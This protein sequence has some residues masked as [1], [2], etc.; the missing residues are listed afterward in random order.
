MDHDEW[1]YIPDSPEDLPSTVKPL[2][3]HDREVQELQNAFSEQRLKTPQETGQSLYIWKK[4]DEFTKSWLP[5]R[6][7]V[8]LESAVFDDCIGYR[9]IRNGYAYT[10][11]L[12]AFGKKKTALLDGNY[13]AHLQELPF[14]AQST[15]LILYLH[16]ARRLAGENMEYRVQH[17]SGEDSHD[18]ELWRL[19]RINGR[20]ILQYYPYKEMLDRIY[21]LMYAFNREDTDI[22]DC[23]IVDMDAKVSG[24]TEN[25]NGYFVN[26]GFY[27]ALRNAH[28]KH[29][30][31]KLGYVRYN[32]VVY[33]AVPYIDG[34]GFF[35]LRLDTGT[36][37]I[38]EITGYPFDGGERKV[39]EFIKAG[40][41]EDAELFRDIPKLVDVEPLPPAETERFAL[42]AFFSNGDCRKYVLPIDPA[43]EQQEAVSSFGHVFTDR[44]WSSGT[45]LSRHASR[46]DGYPEC[47]PA[48]V[49]KNGF[50]IAGLRCYTEG[51]PYSEPV[52]TDEIVYKDQTLC[53]KK[54]WSWDVESIYQDEETGLLRALISGQAF[55]QNGKSTL[56]SV[57]GRRLTSLTF[58]DLSTFHDGL[59]RI[60]R[61]NAGY[62]YI[63]PDMKIAI[64]MEHTWAEDFEHGMAKA[65]KGGAWCFLR[66]DGSR[67]ILRSPHIDH[68]YQDVGRFSDGLCRVSTIKL[69]FM[70]LA[71]HSDTAFI[72]GTWG[73]VDLQGREVIAPQYIYAYD[74]IGG[75]ALVAKGK[76]TIDSKWDNEYNQGRYW[77]DE[78]LWGGIDLSGREVIPCIFDE[79]KYLGEKTGLYCAHYGGWEKG[80]WGV[81]DQ[82]GKWVVDPVFDEIGCEFVDG[83]FAFRA[84]NYDGNP[85]EQPWGIFDAKQGE[86][87][88]APQFLDVSFVDGE[89][90]CVEVFDKFLGRTV[91]KLLDRS[92]QELFKSIYTGIYTWKA[93]YEVYIR[94]G[95]TTRHG[96]INKDGSIVLP[97]IYDIAWNGIDTERKRIT[98]IQGKKQ[99]V[100]DFDGNVIIPPIYH[101]II[102][103]RAPLLTMRVG[104]KERY[105]EGVMT[106][107]GQEVLPARYERISWCADQR[108]FFCCGDGRCEMYQ[109]ETKQVRQCQSK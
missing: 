92:G 97:C 82:N 48:I 35:S 50:D 15:V 7:Y 28:Q 84:G 23:I 53:V 80:R 105:T 89:T 94:D 21:Q 75:I 29:G 17:Y 76:W 90:I 34:L 71:F 36:Y 106:L 27:H 104:D 26:D 49:F 24:C 16:V 54:I 109:V 45:V 32:D 2:I 74:F 57:N 42:K 68:P 40:Q 63:T 81:V 69:T 108:H 46:Y 79:I 19:T 107:S 85:D 62:G 64:P 13:C 55:N 5:R 78:E 33:S 86:V 58:D 38:Q 52:L 101:E 61:K 102:N 47:G 4:A 18:P 22:Y 56:I 20:H 83:M 31:M 91:E 12:Y 103:H 93:P 44:I 30:D 43:D 10:V 9:C 60:A 98:F 66:T 25:C 72:A 87:L 88:L 65:Q 100:V 70:D 8:V 99:G 14:S 77:T 95:D 67:L 73:F 1:N 3:S 6:G 11:F 59:A 41:C 96:L 51:E 39:A 37:R